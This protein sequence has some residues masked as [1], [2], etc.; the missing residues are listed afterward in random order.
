MKSHVLDANALYR[1]LMDQPGADL[2]EGLF[3]RARDSTPQC[4]YRSS[5]GA[6]ATFTTI[7]LNN[8]VSKEHENVWEKCGV[9]LLCADVGSDNL[10]N[11]SKSLR[12]PVHRSAR[13]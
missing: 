2:V 5:T 13:H 8:K 7:L 4:W 10:W 9:D 12:P 1:F 6:S 11:D 3:K